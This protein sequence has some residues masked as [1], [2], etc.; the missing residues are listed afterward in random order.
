VKQPPKSAQ[1]QQTGI[2]LIIIVITALV[3]IGVLFV[4]NLGITQARLDRDKV[5]DEALKKAKVAL[6]A[7]AT[8]QPLTTTSA[9][10]PGLLPC[11]DLNDD[12]LAND[13]SCGD[14]IGSTA[15]GQINRLGR[16]PWKTLGIEDLRDGYGER[17][18][19]AVSSMYKNNAANNGPPAS[20]DLGLNPDTGLGTI[21]LRDSSGNV[22]YDGTSTDVLNPNSGGAV[23]L[24]IAPGPIIT[25]Q[26][27]GSPQDRTCNGGS[28]DTAGKCTS[29][30]ASLTA[31]CNPINYLDVALGEDNSNFVDRNDSRSGNSNG[32]I[33]G[34]VVQTGATLVNDRIAALTYNDIM[35]AM[36]QRVAREVL[37]CLTDYA[38]SSGNDG[39]FWD[40]RNRYPW[41]APACRIDNSDTTINWSDW[42]NVLF[43]RIPDPP[44]NTTRSDSNN[45]MKQNQ[46][47]YDPTTLNL[48]SVTSDLATAS[49]WDAWK[50]YVFYALAQNYRPVSG[51]PPALGGPCSTTSQCL[52]VV[53]SSGSVLASGKQVAVIVSGSPLNTVSP[54]QSHGGSNDRYPENFLEKTNKD[55]EAMNT[56][57]PVS[58]CAGY[59]HPATCSPLSNCNRLSLSA[60]LRD[61]ND[62]VAFYP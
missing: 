11:P 36:M 38:K 17:L 12:G 62:V 32:F 24:I 15:A 20:P 19:Y 1:K 39:E 57:P 2:A 13:G 52:Q 3:V 47:Y 43:G 27:A 16:L 53:D 22:I 7:Y 46:W 40:N 4:A 44:F 59:P 14:E 9:V 26:G 35:P 18:W 42:S 50:K 33:Q 54:V 60:R 23:A 21:T 51:S 34:P 5:T 30:P 28:C 61:L 25:R 45:Y 8:T 10:G 29:S 58:Q 49:W 56:N 6:I 48:C 55:L 41:P 31:K 37:H